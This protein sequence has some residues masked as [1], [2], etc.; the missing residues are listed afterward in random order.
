MKTIG[1]ALVLW[2]AG[3]AATALSLTAAGPDRPTLAAAATL[4]LVA[5]LHP[6][7]RWV[8]GWNWSTTRLT[9]VGVVA[10]VL[11]F[12]LEYVWRNVSGAGWPP[13]A[14]LL[15]GLRNL[16]LVLGTLAG[17]RDE[18]SEN[19]TAGAAVFGFLFAFA[20][21]GPPTGLTLLFVPYALLGSLWLARRCWR[22]SGVVG[23][24]LPVAPLMTTLA[25]AGISAGLLA[26]GP[27]GAGRMLYQLMPTSGG[28]SAYDRFARG[29]VGDEGHD[30]VDAEDQAKS[31]GGDGDSFVESHERTF[32]DVM[33]EKLGEPF[34]PKD[35]N[36]AVS[37]SSN[38]VSRE[39]DHAKNER[40]G[41]SFSVYRRSVQ[42]RRRPKDLLADALLYVEGRPPA[43][44]PTVVFDR[45]DGVR[46]HEEERPH[47]PEYL[48]GDAFG[49][50]RVHDRHAEA[51]PDIY[52]AGRRY[53]VK[54]GKYDGRALPLPTRVG[55]LRVGLVD[56][57]DFF[58]QTQTGRWAVA[59]PDSKLPRSEW[60]EC[61][62]HGYDAER[63]AE[64]PWPVRRVA[65]ADD[66]PIGRTAVRW[67]DGCATGW[68]QV[69]A[70]VSRLRQLRRDDARTAT[71]NG[72]ATVELLETGAGPDY[73]FATAAVRLLRSLG[74]DC[75]LVGGYYVDP[76]AFDQDEGLTPLHAIDLH[77]WPIVKLPD[78]RFLPIEPTPGYE[79]APPRRSLW[80]RLL[81]A[82]TAVGR[83]LVEHPWAAFAGVL[84]MA[85]AAW[86]RRRLADAAVT[87]AW[88]G[89]AALRRC[90]V[91]ATHRLL[92]R[93]GRIAGAGRDQ[94]ATWRQW[95]RGRVRAAAACGTE[96]GAADLLTLCDR[97]ESLWY[98]GESKA[99]D[100][101]P[102]CRRVAGRWSAARLRRR[103]TDGVNESKGE[104]EKRQAEQAFLPVSP[105]PHRPLVLHATG[106]SR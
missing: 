47:R 92:E 89:E 65:S 63:V 80:A 1:D 41:R 101:R 28:D 48:H 96:D 81:G 71:G 55:A 75:R 4:A 27:R 98:G 24:G 70:V 9:V 91:T 34:K 16:L 52:G 76:A 31:S 35:Q 59:D 6:L 62:S 78:G 21:G 90:P 7:R 8:I 106:E 83:W 56:R 19:L 87:L 25:L 67:T 94:G 44:L 53:R 50:L 99:A 79:L 69:R 30:T 61:V 57:A 26:A 14:L 88:H 51:A 64:L 105:S 38:K 102:L 49:W 12:A 60:L 74:H 11:P 43:H 32:Y 18:L 17:T 39:H 93:R 54:V 23:V 86:C 77:F 73:R 37:L 5:A 45:F 2:Q 95:T 84:L 3:L 33:T 72:D 68:Q 85:L 97:C 20:A 29:G 36:R 40:A 42:E 66:D 100:D 10:V 22:R 82:T 15:A 103:R 104:W 58:T 13:E 46:W